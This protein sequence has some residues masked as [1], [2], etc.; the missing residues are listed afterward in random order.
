[1]KRTLLALAILAAVTL[2]EHR[3]A[4]AG[5]VVYSSKYTCNQ[6]TYTVSYS[7]AALVVASNV[8]TKTLL[9]LPARTKVCL[10]SMAPQT[11]A[12][13]TGI[14]DVQCTLG[15]ATSGNES[16]Y[17]PALSIF[18]TAATQSRAGALSGT[19]LATPDSD[20]TVKLR[21]VSTGAA[22]GNGSTTN[23]TSGKVWITVGTQLL[24]PGT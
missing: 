18:Q 17:L 1:M 22:F 8:A 10:A 19:D 20:L 14:S 4:G 7:D 5:S 16:I 6:T 9:T 13:G 23:L 21:C 24:R 2:G 11:I 12:A 3:P 15:S